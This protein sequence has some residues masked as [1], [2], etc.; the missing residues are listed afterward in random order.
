[1]LWTLGAD[2]GSRVW[3][4]GEIVAIRQ[5]AFGESGGTAYVYSLRA[6][7]FTYVVAFTSPLKAYLHATVKFAVEKKSLCVQDLDGKARNSPIVEQI[8]NTRPHR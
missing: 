7:D 1:M 5:D 4:S 2:T 3:Q 6:K 8:E